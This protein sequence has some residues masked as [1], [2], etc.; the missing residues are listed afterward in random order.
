MKKIYLFFV[1]I[2]ALSAVS[3]QVDVTLTII[4]LGT[5]RTNVKVK[6]TMDAWAQHPMTS[7]GNP[8]PTT[9]TYTYSIPT[10]A[11][12][13]TYEWG[14][15]ADGIA[16]LLNAPY[17][18]HTGNLQFT[19]NTAGVVSGET[20][21]TLNVLTETV[22]FNVYMGNVAGFNPATESVSIRGS[23]TGWGESQAYVMAD[24]DGDKIYTLDSPID[25][26]PGNNIEFKFLRGATWESISGNRT[27]TV[28]DGVNSYCGKFEMKESV[29][30][31]VLDVSQLSTNKMIS[32]NPSTGIFNLPET[33]DYTV[34]DLTGKTILSGK[35]DKFDLSTQQNGVYFVRIATRETT[36]IQKVVKK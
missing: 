31:N 9:W 3:A 14:A 25:F 10:P 5:G 18:T 26:L 7:D 4:D 30:C 22:S 21:F 15:V 20:S 17:G 34:M 1:G 13:T 35:S 33:A 23:F 32:P 19:V 24:T 16:W 29:D 28:I 36:T 6:G 8:N 2:L 27:Y 11:V 12:E